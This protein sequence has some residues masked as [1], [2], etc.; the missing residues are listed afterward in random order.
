VLPAA[1][2]D[3]ILNRIDCFG[4][5]L[6]LSDRVVSVVF[7]NPG[8]SV[9]RDLQTNRAF[10]D[11][12]TG[13]HWD[14]FFA[15]LSAF[16]SVEDD[17]QIIG[18]YYTRSDF[19]AF[20]N[21]RAFSEIEQWVAQGHRSALAREQPKPRPWTYKGGTHVVSFMAYAGDPDW[22]SLKSIPLYTQKG[23]PLT[24]V[25]VT[26]GL[27]KWK[28][29]RVDPYLAPGEGLSNVAVQT[30]WLTAALGWTASA[31][32]GGVLGNAAYELVRKLL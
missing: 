12:R 6:P 16:A 17:A 20:Y 7:A 2:V 18:A 32:A 3:D 5:R 9:W 28:E 24:L 4:D 29:D 13:D 31:A 26:E 27:A 25:H 15:G 30:A 22:L 19:P 21:P 8:S 14:L 1:S 10:L 23:E 11:E